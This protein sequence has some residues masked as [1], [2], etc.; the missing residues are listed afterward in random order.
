MSLKYEPACVVR[1][2]GGDPDAYP[3]GAPMVLTMGEVR[4]Q[5]EVFIDNL[6]VRIHF[7]IAMIR[8]TG[9]APWGFEFPF[10]VHHGRGACPPL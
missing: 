1:Q 7:I 4:V 2:V 10:P 8:W 9:L 3:M 5:R 6:L